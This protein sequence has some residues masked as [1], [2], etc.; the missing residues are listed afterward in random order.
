MTDGVDGIVVPIDNEG[1]ADG[2]ARLLNDD[3]S[4]RSISEYLSVNDFGNV[5]EAD[6][7]RDLFK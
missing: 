3:T 2:I 6:R 4:I 1:C 5:S 7:I